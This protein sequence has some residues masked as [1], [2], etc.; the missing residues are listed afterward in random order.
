[1]FANVYECY[2]C[3]AATPW[4]VSNEYSMNIHCRKTVQYRHFIFMTSER[5]CYILLMKNAKLVNKTI[6]FVSENVIISK[7]NLGA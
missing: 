7:I 6:Y 4:L 5:K 3:L 1:M 2:E